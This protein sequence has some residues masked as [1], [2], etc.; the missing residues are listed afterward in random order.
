MNTIYPQPNK[1]HS[2]RFW[3]KIGLGVFLCFLILTPFGRRFTTQLFN[4]LLKT[5][6]LV[7][8]KIS[9]FLNYF[10]SKKTLSQE[11]VRLTVAL[12]QAQAQ[13]ALYQALK[14]ENETLRAVLGKKPDTANF[15]LAQVLHRP[16]QSPYDTLIVDLGQN[17]S[18]Q[19]IRAG[20]S[21][22]IEGEWLIGEVAAV[23]SETAKV[24]LFSGANREL[25]VTLGESGITVLAQGRGGGNF[26]VELPRGVVVEP[27]M[28]VK[29]VRNHKVWPIGLVAQVRGDPSDAFQTVLFKNPVNVYEIGRV[30]IVSESW[31]PKL[32]SI[33]GWDQSSFWAF[34]V[35]RGFCLWL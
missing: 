28:L 10:A 1:R 2:A 12:N 17:N 25:P 6:S 32:I 23:Y 13:A 3:P 27:G 9:G 8:Q 15:V 5:N 24:G 29:T 16:N 35:C 20:A 4:P 7:G 18:T 22:T 31:A 14:Q 19:A 26:L 33:G 11:N 21:V 30:E 34:L